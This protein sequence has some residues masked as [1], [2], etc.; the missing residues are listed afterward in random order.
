MRLGYYHCLFLIM[1]WG[2]DTIAYGQNIAIKTMAM[3]PFDKTAIEQPCFDNNGDTCALLK[4][5][6]DNLVGIE[7]TNSNQYIKATYAD[8]IYSVYLPELSRKLDFQHKDYMPVQLDVSEFGY[9]KLRKGK[10]Y[11]VVLD[12][13]KKTELKSSVI[14]KTDPQ[15]AKVVFDKKLLGPSM[16]GTYEIP[17]TEGVYTYKVEADNYQPKEGAI[18]V[19]KSEVKTF[20]IRLPPI[21][22]EV[23]VK[24]NVEKAR[25]FVD[26]I[27]HGKIGKVMIPQGEH[28]IRVQ[29]EGYVDS[30]KHVSIGSSTDYL[31]FVLKE[32][33]RVTHVHATPV[34]IYSDSPS[35][36]KDNKKIKEWSDGEVI[37]FMPGK[38]QLSDD[39]GN[40]KKIIVTSKPMTVHLDM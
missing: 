17:V 2:I 32:N 27:D 21:T 40:T 37:L 15:K 30:E 35:I 5:K 12:A 18:S 19:A 23:D 20:I 25:V 13:P 22:H 26:N 31:S 4:I 8:G 29:A 16:N 33:K 9:K 39:R 11:L 10:T 1:F 7:F 28:T 38:Y 34:Q 14:L 6:T 24:C 3:Q 36:Y